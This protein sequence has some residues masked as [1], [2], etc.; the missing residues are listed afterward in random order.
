MPAEAL[1]TPV[2]KPVGTPGLAEG[3]DE[4]IAAEHPANTSATDRTSA[5]IRPAREGPAVIAAAVH[6]GD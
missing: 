2:G 6:E 3:P 4:G 5:R 1:G